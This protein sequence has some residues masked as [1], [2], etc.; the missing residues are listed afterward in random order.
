MRISYLS[1]KTL[2]KKMK[3]LEKYND[4]EAY[5]YKNFVFNNE[6]SW[7]LKSKIVQISTNIFLHLFL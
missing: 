1:K 5:K 3:N 4:N 7:Y 2:V 6:K